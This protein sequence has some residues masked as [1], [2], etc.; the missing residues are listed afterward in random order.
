MVSD[1]AIGLLPLRAS[2][3]ISPDFSFHQ[4]GIR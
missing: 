2:A 3:G 4:I 1:E